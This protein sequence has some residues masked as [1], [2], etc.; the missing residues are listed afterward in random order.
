MRYLSLT[1]SGTFSDGTAVGNDNS[2]YVN[3]IDNVV[4]VATLAIFFPTFD[5]VYS[6][7]TFLIVLSTQVVLCYAISSEF[8][9]QWEKMKDVCVTEEDVRIL[10]ALLLK[11][12]VARCKCRFGIF[13]LVILVYVYYANIDCVG[14]T[15]SKECSVGEKGVC[16]QLMY[17]ICACFYYTAAASRLIYITKHTPISRVAY[18]LLRCVSVLLL[19][20]ALIYSIATSAST[21]VQQSD[22]PISR[23]NAPVPVIKLY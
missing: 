19:S 22:A 23:G 1:L 21:A 8:L 18:N 12:G 20:S 14:Y 15:P 16:T 11:H 4:C 3:L 9:C 6:T 10:N 17:S 7:T 13:A 5:D 2:K